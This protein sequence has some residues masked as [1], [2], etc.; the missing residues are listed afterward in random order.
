MIPTTPK[1]DKF[2]TVIVEGGTTISRHSGDR[3]RQHIKD[4]A[5]CNNGHLVQSYA[6]ISSKSQAFT[7]APRC[8]PFR[9]QRW[10]WMQQ[11]S[12]TTEDK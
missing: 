12:F 4:D 1:L 7:D 10:D 9:K 2:F 5:S 6:I 8:L 3:K 11:E